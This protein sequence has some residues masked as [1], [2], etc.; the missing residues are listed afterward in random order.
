MTNKI[1]QLLE[2]IIT[3]VIRSPINPLLKSL[4]YSIPIFPHGLVQLKNQIHSLQQKNIAVMMFTFINHCKSL[5]TC[6]N[7]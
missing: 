2:I 3:K 5:N 4:A 7:I 6:R 1:F